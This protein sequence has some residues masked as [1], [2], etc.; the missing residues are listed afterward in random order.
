MS[1]RRNPLVALLE[2]SSEC[3]IAESPGAPADPLQRIA[4]SSGSAGPS[5]NLVVGLTSGDEA[6]EPTRLMD[7]LE[8]E[9]VEE[10]LETKRALTELHE[11]SSGNAERVVASGGCLPAASGSADCTCCSGQAELSEQVQ[12]EECEWRQ[13]HEDEFESVVPAKAG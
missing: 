13:P 2:S 6:A 3:P 9:R 1:A 5:F 12:D 11:L 8:A 7:S 4:R 10:Q